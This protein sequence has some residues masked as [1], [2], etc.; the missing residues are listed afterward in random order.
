MTKLHHWRF[1]IALQACDKDCGT[2]DDGCGGTLTCNTCPAGEQC[3][4]DG[5]CAPVQ[6]PA[7]VPTRTQCDGA[8]G[9]CVCVDAALSPL[10]AA[11]PPLPLPLPPPLPPPRPFAA[12]LPSPIPHSRTHGKTLPTL[13]APPRFDGT[14][15]KQ[16]EA[17]KCGTQDNGCGKEILCGECDTANGYYCDVDQAGPSSECQLVTP[18]PAP[19][20]TTC[21]GGQT[22]GVQ[23]NNCGEIISCGSC[24][25]GTAC[26]S[27]GTACEAVPRPCVPMTTCFNQTCGTTGDGCGGE[28]ICGPACATPDPPGCVALTQQQ[29]CEGRNCGKVGDGCDTAIFDCGSCT[30]GYSCSSDGSV[31]T[32][33]AKA[34]TPKTFCSVQCGAE[35]DGCGGE[36]AGRAS[37]QR[38]LTWG[39]TALDAF[40]AAPGGSG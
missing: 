22:C 25:F 11:A 21:T 34:C 32:A 13:L 35:P 38:T 3:L 17:M 4:F 23:M 31:C 37:L 12:T 26:N 6:P 40:M 30:D 8:R 16:T 15:R 14:P 39:C 20:A 9:L 27:L 33:P 7:C 19:C 36:R 2:E 18:P 28:V 5:T 24:P 29:A 1:L 10:A